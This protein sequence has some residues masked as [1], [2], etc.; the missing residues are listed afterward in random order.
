MKSYDLV[1]CVDSGDT[2]RCIVCCSTSRAIYPKDC[3]ELH[4]AIFRETETQCSEAVCDVCHATL[5]NRVVHDD[6]GA[7]G[8]CGASK[9]P[10]GYWS[11]VERDAF[12]CEENMCDVC[13]REGVCAFE[14]GCSCWYGIPCID[15]RDEPARSDD[16]VTLEDIAGFGDDIDQK[17]TAWLFE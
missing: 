1:G 8:Y 16:V 11:A 6:G 5:G 13:G 17:M 14:H 10:G 12:L 9:Y 15:P 3:E 4:T 2:I 7:C